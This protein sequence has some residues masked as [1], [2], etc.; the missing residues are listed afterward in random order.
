MFG[1]ILAKSSAYVVFLSQSIVEAILLNIFF[2]END[3]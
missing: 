3:I 2:K 1:I